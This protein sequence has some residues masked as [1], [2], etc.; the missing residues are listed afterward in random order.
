VR[1]DLA[2]AL[3][4][5]DPR[6][7]W[8]VGR[9]KI[10]TGYSARPQATVALLTFSRPPGSREDQCL[11]PSFFGGGLSVSAMIRSWSTFRGRPGRGSSVNP[12]IPLRSYRARQPITVGRDTATRGA[13]GATRGTRHHAT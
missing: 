10:I 11:T 1:D 8:E 4:L 6:R 13:P 7:S 5:L 3:P 2:A 12:P 9:G